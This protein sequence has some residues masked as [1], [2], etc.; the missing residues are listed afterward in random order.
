LRDA[1]GGNG[2]P[3]RPPPPP[4]RSRGGRRRAAGPL[5]SRERFS[6]SGRAE[7]GR[8]GS[9]RG[10]RGGAVVFFAG[11]PSPGRLGGG[12]ERGRGGGGGGGERGGGGGPPRRA[13]PRSL[14]HHPPRGRFRPPHHPRAARLPGGAP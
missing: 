4:P 1:P 2:A 14:P 10:V 7:L 9:G 12:W 13:S 6:L 8:A 11:L 5:G 3:P